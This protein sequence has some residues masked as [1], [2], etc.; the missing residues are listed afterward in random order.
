MEIKQS[1]NGKAIASLCLSILSII[2][3]CVWYISFVMGVVSVVLGIIALREENAPQ[4]D[5]AIA[6]IVVGSVGT[7]LAI[8]TA[9][10]YLI[11]LLKVNQ[12]SALIDGTMAFM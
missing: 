1:S 12:V 7:V 5:L 11:S 10:L 3:C 6:G 9:V 2:C 8:S 4:K